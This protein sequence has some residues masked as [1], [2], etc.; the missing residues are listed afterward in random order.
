MPTFEVEFIVKFMT[1]YVLEWAEKCFI[2]GI[3]SFTQ[4]VILWRVKDSLGWV[5]CFVIYISDFTEKKVWIWADLKMMEAFVT[6]D[7]L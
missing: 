5:L 4:M 1:A 3:L 7:F 2:V 6:W